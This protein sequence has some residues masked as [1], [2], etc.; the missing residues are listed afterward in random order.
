M[1]RIVGTPERAIPQT[2]YKSR[3]VA[4]DAPVLFTLQRVDNVVESQ[5]EGASTLTLSLGTAPNKALYPLADTLI[6]LH[7]SD[8][9][10]FVQAYVVNVSD[11]TTSVSVRAAGQGYPNLGVLKSH[12]YDFYVGTND[13]QYS[14]MTTLSVNGIERAVEIR[15]TPDAKGRCE[16]DLSG[17]LYSEVSDE[18]IGDYTTVNVAE[19]NQSGEFTPYFREQYIG[20]ANL[21]AIAG[22][23]YHYVKAVRSK[24]KGVNMSEFIPNVDKPCQILNYFG[25]PTHWLGLPFDVSFIYSELLTGV[26][27]F[28]LEEHYD[29]EN[30]L[31]STSRRDLN[32]NGLGRVNSLTVTPDG[33]EATCSRIRVVLDKDAVTPPV[34]PNVWYITD[35]PFS[36]SHPWKFEKTGDSVKVTTDDKRVVSP[37]PT[38]NLPNPALIPAVA[39]QATYTGSQTITKLANHTESTLYISKIS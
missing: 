17:L 6:W 12:T 18:K 19:V 4:T 34:E 5:S 9:N 15:R 3:W 36:P 14:I 13:V 30:K 31:L 8:T 20:S 2:A 39:R 10:T 35:Y 26:K 22:G 28:A 16:I 1:I 32:P 33:V 38:L 27:L 25:E 11:A 21:S 7:A 23:S 37:L 29:S 24:E